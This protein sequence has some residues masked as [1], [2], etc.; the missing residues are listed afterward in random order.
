MGVSKTDFVRGLQC[1][2]MLWLD[3]H[4]PE[5]KIIPEEV[6]IKLDEGNVFGDG[7]MGIFGEYTETTCYRADGRL[8]YKGMIEK[9]SECLKDGTP[10]ICEAA[11]SWYGN[12]C[13]ADILKKISAFR[14]FCSKSAAWR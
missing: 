7:A 11:F 3:S 13:A 12:Y 9:T 4:R 1:P 6:R 10:V 5:E 2:K 8:D 14:A